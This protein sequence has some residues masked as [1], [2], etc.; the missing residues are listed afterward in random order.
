MKVVDSRKNTVRN[1][2]NEGPSVQRQ[3]RRKCENKNEHN[4]P[5][6]VNIVKKLRYHISEILF[7]IQ[8]FTF[9]FS[10][11]LTNTEYPFFGIVE[12]LI[13]HIRPNLERINLKDNT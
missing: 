10:F 7:I 8:G 1:S 6:N 11:F 5:N 9:F 3:K 13:I 4:T 2:K 12:T